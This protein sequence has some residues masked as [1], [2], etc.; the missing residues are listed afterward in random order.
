M[1]NNVLRMAPPMNVGKADVDE[2]LRLLEESFAAV[3]AAMFATA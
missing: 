3:A 2:A 1:H